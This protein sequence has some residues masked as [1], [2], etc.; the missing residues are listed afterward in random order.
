MLGSLSRGS[1]PL[2]RIQAALFVPRDQSPMPSLRRFRTAV[3][4]NDLRETISRYLGVERTERSFETFERQHG[5]HGRVAGRPD[6]H[7]LRGGERR[8]PLDEPVAPDARD[9][10]VA[11]QVRLA[12]TPA[13]DQHMVA[14]L[15]VRMARLLDRTGEIDA[16]NHRPA[17]HD[18]CLAGE[19]QAVLV[20]Y[21]CMTDFNRDIAFHE[22]GGRDCGPARL[23]SAVPLRQQQGFIVVHNAPR[24]FDLQSA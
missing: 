19:G 9:L 13:V 24:R 22:V 12:Q 21:G 10:R 17:P 18:R 14:W 5:Q 7:G 8:R 15:E 1:K 23:R 20:V 4:A 3:T 6:R 16:G 2:E 11:A